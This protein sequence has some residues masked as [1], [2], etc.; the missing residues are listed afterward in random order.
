MLV[1]CNINSQLKLI[2][3]E[4]IKEAY[5]AMFFVMP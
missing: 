4:K 5:T 3:S 2:I 1:I